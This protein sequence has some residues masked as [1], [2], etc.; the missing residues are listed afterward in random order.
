MRLS[1]SS[2]NIICHDFQIFNPLKFPEPYHSS[3][4]LFLTSLIPGDI[5]SNTLTHLDLQAGFYMGGCER[6]RRCEWFGGY[7]IILSLVIL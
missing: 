4:R 3:L 5:Y 2:T 7:G 1:D 6:H